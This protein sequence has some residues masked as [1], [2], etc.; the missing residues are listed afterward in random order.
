MMRFHRLVL[1]AYF[2]LFILYLFTPLL[3]I[4]I[5]GFRDSNF[6][7]FPITKWTTDWY[8]E[9]LFDRDIQS[10][11]WLSLRVA[12][13]ST[14]ISLFVGLPTAFLVARTRAAVR[15]TL[16]AV[17]MLPAFL[18]VIVSAISLRIFAG[19]IGLETGMLAISLGHAVA[20]MPFVVIMVL[21]R[22][23]SLNSSVVDAARNLGA[24]PI[25]VLT[26]IVLP[27]LS[28]ALF[29]AFLFSMLLSF[30]DF[31]R[32]FFLGGFDQTFP[33]LLYARLRFG[34]D[35]GLAAV[36]T[37]VLIATTCLGLFAERL[38]RGRQEQTKRQKKGSGANG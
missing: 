26:R 23:D 14:A 11:L 2:W 8:R 10:S 36:S 6:V 29:G 20:S 28:P 35:P 12:I 9:I 4:G 21:T 34:F 13:L 37:I 33:V 25:I 5:M 30:E 38:V 32:S 22:I 3:V 7:S 15:A 24:D 17:L 18:P 27:Y 31:V 16:I 19:Q 1:P